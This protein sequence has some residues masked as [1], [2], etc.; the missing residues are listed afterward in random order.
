M[1]MELSNEADK[2]ISDDEWQKVKPTKKGGRKRIKT[3]GSNDD[4]SNIDE[5]KR[6]AETA[7]ALS[8]AKKTIEE[9]TDG[10]ISFVQFIDVLNSGK[11]LQPV[12][13]SLKITDGEKK[14]IEI[15]Q[16]IH[17]LLSDKTMKSRL[18]KLRK[19]LQKLESGAPPDTVVIESETET[20]DTD[21]EFA[22]S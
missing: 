14:I 9:E 8:P 7:L 17:P 18:T 20:A 15:I 4:S 3:D 5:K 19:K 16:K 12:L 22:S 6:L 11:N 1:G 13:D 10:E 2:R 21:S